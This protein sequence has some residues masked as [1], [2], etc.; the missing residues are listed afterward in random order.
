MR[1]AEARARAAD[2]ARAQADEARAQADEARLQAEAEARSQAEART[3]ADEARLQAEAAL[4]AERTLSKLNELALITRTTQLRTLLQDAG[5][6][7][8]EVLRVLPVQYLTELLPGAPPE[9]LEAVQ[10]L[11]LS[12]PPPE[13]AREVEGAQSVHAW[14]G[15]VFSCV[16]ACVPHP[17][18]WKLEHHPAVLSNKGSIPDWVLVDAHDAVDWA[19]VSVFIEAKP[20]CS[21]NKQEKALLLEGEAQ[22]IRYAATALRA[23]Y[24]AAQGRHRRRAVVLVVNTRSIIVR[25][26]SL[27]IAGLDSRIE[28][29]E[30]AQLPW[31]CAADAKTGTHATTGVTLLAHVFAACRED[32]SGAHPLP[33][34]LDIPAGAN[35]VDTGVVSRKL[36]L[37]CRVGVGGHCDVYAS[38]LNDFPVAVKLARA[39]SNEQRAARTRDMVAHEVSVLQRLAPTAASRLP[40]CLAAVF[41]DLHPHA[42]IVMEPLGTPLPLYRSTFASNDGSDRAIRSA[43]RSVEQLARS[44]VADILLALQFSHVRGWA[45]ADVRPSNVIWCRDNRC[46]LVDWGVAMPTGTCCKG[47]VGHVLFAC[48]A[49]LSCAARK[50]PQWW[51]SPATDVECAAYVGAALVSGTAACEPPWAEHL[52][53]S[54]LVEAEEC[55]LLARKTSIEAAPSWLRTLHTCALAAQQLD[56]KSTLVTGLYELQQSSDQE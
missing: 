28:V 35:G 5:N 4:A 39:F 15:G 55:V 12:P 26:V 41:G 45:H 36:E 44:A 54:R 33:K 21:G 11:R 10:R 46:V 32:V 3:R 37:Q 56:D 47:F 14:L 42:F 38:S 16:M 7:G 27:T 49:A 25:V 34:T 53:R 9:V 23:Q 13:E 52:Q 24:A 2:E 6:D 1:A 43:R 18:R 31:P 8:A 19:T 29:H 22:G 40:R 17:P 50:M 48:D 51:V 20:L 30:L